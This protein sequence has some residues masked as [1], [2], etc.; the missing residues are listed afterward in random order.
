MKETRQ[1]HA[2]KM[3]IKCLLPFTEYHDKQISIDLL[4]G[5]FLLTRYDIKPSIDKKLQPILKVGTTVEV[6]SSHILLDIWLYIH[7]VI[8]FHPF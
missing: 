3:R 4:Q 2:Y 6:I 8:K 1:L 7:A 5:T